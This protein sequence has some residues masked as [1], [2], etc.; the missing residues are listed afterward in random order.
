MS[1]LEISQTIFYFISSL[2]VLVIGV[3]LV[4]IIYHMIAV[5]KNT[6]KLSDD[7]AHTYTRAKRGVKKIISKFSK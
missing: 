5:V 7:L 4:I 2:A 6:R 1:I 3:L